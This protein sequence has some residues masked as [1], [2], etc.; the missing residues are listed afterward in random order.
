MQQ[1]LGGEENFTTIVNIFREVR[2]DFTATKQNKK[3]CH[4]ERKLEN[5]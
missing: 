2:K 5:K 4:L 1:K 3:G